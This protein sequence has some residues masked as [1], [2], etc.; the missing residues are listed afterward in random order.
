M[1]RKSHRESRSL[2]VREAKKLYQKEFIRWFKLAAEV[3]S[4]LVNHRAKHTG[5]PTLYIMGDEDHMFL[6]SID[7]LVKNLATPQVRLQVINSCGHVVN[8]DQ[9]DSFNQISIGFLSKR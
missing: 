6:P 7:K 9:P 2:F 8:V 3:N 1:P 5:H 4:L